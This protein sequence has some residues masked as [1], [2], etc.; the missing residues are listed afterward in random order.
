MII[1]FCDSMLPHP[2]FSERAIEAKI[3]S[4]TDIFLDPRLQRSMHDDRS[5]E[6][7][8]M[9]AL[10]YFLIPQTI[11]V[12]RDRKSRTKI[13]CA[14]NFFLPSPERKDNSSCP[15]VGFA[16]DKVVSVHFFMCQISFEQLEDDG[17]AQSVYA[18]SMWKE[19]KLQLQM[20]DK[21]MNI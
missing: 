6:Q 18:K 15:S 14:S 16:L 10:G 8:D 13:H 5:S 19:Q 1:F 3:Y 4:R 11:V 17:S 2:F 9:Q 20:R 7:Q 21:L 12:C